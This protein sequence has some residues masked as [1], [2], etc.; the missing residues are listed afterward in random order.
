[1]KIYSKRV[2]LNKEGSPSTGSVVVF[3][4]KIK[5]QPDKPSERWTFIEFSDCSTKVRLH[6]AGHDTVVDMIEKIEKIR[7]VLD[8]F[9]DHLERHR[10]QDDV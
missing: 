3:D 4:G 7:A 2:W 9:A 10:E 5:Y 8:E 6:K 1:M